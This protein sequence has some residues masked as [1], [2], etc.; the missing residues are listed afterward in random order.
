M[1]CC[2]HGYVLPIWLG[3]WIQNSLN[4]GLLFHQTFLRHGWAFQKLEQIDKDSFPPKF[5]I[6]VGMTATVIPLDRCIPY[7]L[8]D[9][10]PLVFAMISTIII[11]FRTLMTS[12]EE[13]VESVNDDLIYCFSCSIFQNCK[14][15]KYFVVIN[16]KQ[17]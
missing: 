14:I 15:L 8:T 3:F 2:G 11:N 9:A 17:R 6:K 7:P 16:K 13:L 5:I 1:T 4:E 12:G 10:Y